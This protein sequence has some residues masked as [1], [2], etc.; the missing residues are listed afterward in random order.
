[1]EKIKQLLKTRHKEAQKLKQEG[2]RLIGYFC[3]YCP[4]EIVY[5]AGL[6]PV[7]IFDTPTSY[8]RQTK[9]LQSYY[10]AH[11]HGCLE[12]G[13]RGDYDYL[14]GIVLPYACDHTRSAYESWRVNKLLRYTRFIDMPSQVDTLIAKE[15]FMQELKSFTSSLE[16]AFQVEITTNKISQGIL[17]CNENRRL[18]R[19]LFELKKEDRSPVSGSDTF[20]AIL[21][22]T[23][24]SKKFHTEMVRE[25][26]SNIDGRAEGNSGKK[27]IMLMGTELHSDQII[28]YIE[29]NGGFVAADELCTGTRYIWND[30][31]EEK[32]VFEALAERYLLGVNCPIKRPGTLRMNHIEKM[33]EEF[34]IDAVIHLHPKNCD[35]LSWEEPFIKKML[36]QKGIPSLFLETETEQ[37]MK[38][39]AQN[40]EALLVACGN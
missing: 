37:T 2:N 32:E 28:A 3:S 23:I 4:E 6:I 35:P 10:C 21:S 16:K 9:H 13:L 7:R 31:D 39:L 30:V 12:A 15:F 24:S 14:D 33:L 29:N 27:R 38:S 5:A 22:S 18:L 25:C 34:K 20:L 40:L 19:R 1:M 36:D 8:P 26:L 11:C 17:L